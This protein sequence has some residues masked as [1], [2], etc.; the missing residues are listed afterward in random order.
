MNCEETKC[1]F[2]MQGRLRSKVDIV[3]IEPLPS[4]YCAM[5]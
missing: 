5:E 4:E 1:Q 3:A 2:S